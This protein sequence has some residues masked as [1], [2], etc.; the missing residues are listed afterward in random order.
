MRARL[1]DAPS[2]PV[3]GHNGSM[4]GQEPL[5]EIDVEALAR[6]HAA[7]AFVL[8]VRQP[9]EYDEAHVPGA[10]LVPL[11]Q[12][13]ARIGE[14]P[15]GEHLFV[16]CRSGARSAAAVEALIGAGHQATNVAGGTLAWI[17]AGHPTVSGPDAGER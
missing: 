1:S 7:G 4:P 2:R 13:S 11:D 9:D 17:D 8:D 5:P 16:I 15:A 12:L 14:V 6:A 10:V 3:T